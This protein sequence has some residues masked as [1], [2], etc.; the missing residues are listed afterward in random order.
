M[1]NITAFLIGVVGGAIAGWYGT[2][3]YYKTESDIRVKNM[4]AFCD[5]TVAEANRKIND[6]NA[7]VE[8][9]EVRA[10]RAADDRQIFAEALTRLNYSGDIVMPGHATFSYEEKTAHPSEEDNYFSDP[11]VLGIPLTQELQQNEEQRKRP[12]ELIDEN[13]FNSDTFHGF[14][15]KEVHWYPKDGVLLDGDNNELMDDPYSFLG[16]EWL[17]IVERDGEAYVRNFRWEIDYLVLE[18]SGL[19]M[20]NMSIPT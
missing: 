11:E 15:Q 20:D 2:K 6:A 5:Q 3:R 13:T 1:K 10:Q 17:S 8:N 9:A 18:C 7:K 14:E 16:T 19:G 4:Q 12:P